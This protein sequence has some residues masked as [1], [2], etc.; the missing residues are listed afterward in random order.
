MKEMQVSIDCP[1]VAPPAIG[2][3]REYPGTVWCTLTVH[4][5]RYSVPLQSAEGV[6][7]ITFSDLSVRRRRPVRG[8]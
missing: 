6:G 1:Q 8:R 5:H 3:L 4:V 7:V 2:G